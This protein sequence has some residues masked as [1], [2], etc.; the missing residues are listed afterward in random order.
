MCVELANFYF[1]GE[2]VGN[3]HIIP[4]KI[5]SI[6][7]TNLYPQQGNANPL[8]SIFQS[9]QPVEGAYGFN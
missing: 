2:K 6:S 4:L 9:N 8:T 5:L 3:F 1:T 7:E